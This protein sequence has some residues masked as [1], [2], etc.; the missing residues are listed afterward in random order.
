MINSPT[1]L[2][3]W[4]TFVAANNWHGG[5]ALH[6]DTGMNRLGLTPEEAVA[7]APRV[8]TEGHGF[9]LLRATSP[10]PKRPIIR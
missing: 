2:A 8:Q 7:I 9:K 10:A 5:A 6:I 3:E 1:E 4:D